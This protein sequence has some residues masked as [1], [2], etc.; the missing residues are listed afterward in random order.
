MQ[1]P[2]SWRNNRWKSGPKRSNDQTLLIS[3]THLYTEGHHLG[4]DKGSK[5]AVDFSSRP[6]TYDRFFVAFNSPMFEYVRPDRLKTGHR[7]LTG[8]NDYTPLD[9]G[10]RNFYASHRHMPGAFA[11]SKFLKPST[12][13][14]N[15]LKTT[16]PYPKL[17]HGFLGAPANWNWTAWGTARNCQQTPIFPGF[18]DL[19]ILSLKIC[20]GLGNTLRRNV[21]T[22]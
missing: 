19:R 7:Q 21:K 18:T 4:L 8:E 12:A 16:W 13:K 1:L 2:S 15:L 6:S 3:T 11:V 17:S 20:L 22:F 9:F 14:I 10:A 5:G